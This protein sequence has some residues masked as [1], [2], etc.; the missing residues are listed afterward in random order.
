MVRG[1]AIEYNNFFFR[2][3][4]ENEGERILLDL[5]LFFKKALYI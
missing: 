2:N 1:Q 5:F 3:F 4:V